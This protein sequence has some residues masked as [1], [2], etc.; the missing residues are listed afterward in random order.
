MNQL[1]FN[2][3]EA[4]LQASGLTQG[5]VGPRT[6]PPASSPRLAGVHGVELGAPP[7]GLRG[8][9][10][11]PGPRGPPP[12]S[13]G[14]ELVGR[15]PPP[16]SPG[17]AGLADQQVALHSAQQVLDLLA[18]GAN[19]SFPPGQPPQYR[20]PDQEVLPLVSAEHVFGQG[21]SGAL[22]PRDPGF[23]GA[24]PP[25]QGGPTLTQASC[26]QAPYGHSGLAGPQFQPPCS[27]PQFQQMGT[28]ELHRAQQATTMPQGVVPPVLQAQP[29]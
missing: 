11:G 22:C 29:G 10:G 14:G 25:T 28:Q 9:P 4:L 6:F 15:P 8:P 1:Q 23:L 2:N 17:G 24:P 3:M 7:P 12:P 5:S 26:Y 20:M 18:A 27:A 21:G 16:P 13:P 19:F